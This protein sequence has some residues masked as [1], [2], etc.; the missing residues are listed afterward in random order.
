MFVV[1]D[2][3]RRLEKTYVPH[4]AGP[5]EPTTLLGETQSTRTTSGFQFSPQKYGGAQLPFYL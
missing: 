4:T 2:H 5:V 3:A 1:L